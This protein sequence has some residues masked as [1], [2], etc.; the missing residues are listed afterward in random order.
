MNKLH[1]KAIAGLLGVLASLLATTFLPAWTFHYWQA[2]VCLAVFFSSAAAITIYLAKRDPEL[3]ARRMKAGARA[4]NEKS[5]KVI[6]SFARIFFLTFFVVSA[7]DHR[8]GWSRVPA[9]VSIAGDAL[10]AIGFAIIFVVF[11]ENTYTSGVIEIAAGQKVISTGPYLLVRHP[12]YSGA[13]LML[14]GIPIALGSWWGLLLFPLIAGA[15]VWRLLDEEKFLAANLEGY[16]EYLG[17]VIHRLL[18]HVW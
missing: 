15:I 6:Q 11:R 7:L 16:P 5:Q 13:L 18:P 10:I 17:R 12:M 4:E 9:A 1:M 3:L 8:F 2:W 14:L